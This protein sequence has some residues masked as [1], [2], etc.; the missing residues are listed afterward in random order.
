MRVHV[1]P[2][3]LF[4][5]DG[6]DLTLA[7]PITI[8]EASLGTDLKVPTLDGS[9]VTIRIPPGTQPG[10]IFRVRGRGAK[11]D[12]DLLVT[13]E[14]IVPVDLSRDQR[15]AMEALAAASTDDPR[16]HLRV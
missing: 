16:S 14:V 3:R 15:S 8:A 11:A 10:R 12:A 6:D 4:G 9:T 2:H 13:V 5:R 7:V 1:S